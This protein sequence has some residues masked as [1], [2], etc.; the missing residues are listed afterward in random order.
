M[1]PKWGKT[2]ALRGPMA[3]PVQPIDIIINESAGPGEI[4]M[5]VRTAQS[6]GKTPAAAALPLIRA[7]DTQISFPLEAL[8]GIVGAA[9]SAIVDQ[10][11]VAAPLAAQHALAAI[12]AAVQRRIDVVLPTGKQ[13]PVSNYFLSVA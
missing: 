11:Q 13:R 12:T 9:V 3:R 7:H 4:F 8:G 2:R 1:S 6:P 5:S 10:A